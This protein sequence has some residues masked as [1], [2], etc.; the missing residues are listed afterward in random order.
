MGFMI[1]NNHEINKFWSEENHEKFNANL[2]KNIDLLVDSK[3]N[4][5]ENFIYRTIEELQEED[6]FG[7]AT[8]YLISNTDK[9][10]KVDLIHIFEHQISFIHRVAPKFFKD[11]LPTREKDEWNYLVF[12]YS[13]KERLDD[14][15]KVK[16]DD[17]VIKN[18]DNKSI[19]KYLNPL[20]RSFIRGESILRFLKKSHSSWHLTKIYLK[21]IRGMREERLVVL[22]KVADRRQGLNN[23]DKE[24]IRKV[25]F[26]LERTRSHNEFREKL[27]ELMRKFLAKSDEPLFTAEEMVF[28][29]LPSGESWAETKDILLIALYEKLTIDDEVREELEKHITIEGDGENE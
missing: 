19:M 4:F 11:S 2:V 17:E 29:I 13:N 18:K 26:P 3:I 6:L 12:K 22:K 16:F 15:K 28:Q 1:S 23:G 7:D 24:F 14:G 9:E 10:S 5:F 25:V 21:E 20:I 27:R 8:F